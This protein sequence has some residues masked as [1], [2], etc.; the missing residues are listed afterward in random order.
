MQYNPMY[1]AELSNVKKIF[2][3][4]HM[5]KL[6][7]LTPT[8]KCGAKTNLTLKAEDVVKRGPLL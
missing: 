4:T 6:T 8:L 2:I 7:S 1:G 3:I 5:N